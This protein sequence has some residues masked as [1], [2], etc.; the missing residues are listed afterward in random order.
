MPIASVAWFRHTN[1]Q[2]T[3]IR[4]TPTTSAQE[5]A[6]TMRRSKLRTSAGRLRQLVRL[7]WASSPSEA[8]ANVA[9]CVVAALMPPFVVLLSKRL[10]DL[11]AT[12]SSVERNE[13][14]PIAL[15]L[16]LGFGLQR[17]MMV[18]QQSRERQFGETLTQHADRRFLEAAYSA[19]ISCFDDSAWHDQMQR[20]ARSLV[21]RPANLVRAALQLLGATITC[22]GMF[23][24]LYSVN[25]ALVLIGVA[26][27][28]L[29][30]PFQRHQSREAYRLFFSQTSKERERYY[31]RTLM[32]DAR[33]AKEVRAYD[34]GPH[35][36]DRHGVLVARWLSDLRS[37]T[38]R[39]EKCNLAIAA[40]TATAACAAYLL[41]VDRALMGG[42]TAGDV[43]AMVGAF[44]A[45]VSQ[46]SAASYAVAGLDENA[47]FLDDYFEF[48][49][50][51][52]AL[53]VRD[54]ATDLPARLQGGIQ[55]TDVTFRYPQCTT[56]ALSGLSLDI[57]EGEM[58]AL[59]GANGAGKTTL[60]KLLLRFLDPDAGSVSI[61]GVDLRDV[62]PAQVRSRIG[63]LFSDFATYDLT[64]RENVHFGRVERRT[65]DKEVLCALEAAQA[66]RMVQGLPKGLDSNVGALF[67]GGRDLSAGEKQRLALARLI[68][69][70]A[71]IWILDEP[72][73]ALDVEAEAALFTEFKQL[74]GDRIGILVSHR[75]STVRHADKIALVEHGEIVEMGSHEELISR[76]GKYARLFSLQA[77]GYK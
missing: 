40:I 32:T 23:W 57:G 38:R 17:W 3:I 31:L 1:P 41:V 49:T 34:I 59:V 54:Q 53:T 61:G 25:P 77:A 8:A 21:S 36:H 72:T 65:E 7:M 10:V 12:G 24:I 60:I 45:L 39:T 16:G 55:F 43:A 19:E 9:L 46:L 62:E 47:K 20:A 18:W 52:G 66:L 76:Q 71:D 74:L 11:V 75:F 33:F 63:V 68:F 44:G 51:S 67:Q 5:A 48:L 6:G 69:R 56:P 13:W 58:L 30:I 2:L 29:G 28:V 37:M 14:V 15:L 4:Q 27:V 70:S 26:A 64:A 73:S 22:V 35:F 50:L 42:N